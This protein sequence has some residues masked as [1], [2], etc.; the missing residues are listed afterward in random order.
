MP[1]GPRGP[2]RGMRG[3]A[4]RRAVSAALVPAC[5]AASGGLATWPPRSA[6]ARERMQTP[7]ETGVADGGRGPGADL[8]GHGQHRLPRASPTRPPLRL[9]GRGLRR[10]P[11]TTLAGHRPRSSGS[12]AASRDAAGGG[13]LG[14]NPGGRAEGGS[15][16]PAGWSRLR[17][18]PPAPDRGIA[19]L[20]TGLD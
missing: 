17:L 8:G 7:R 18:D 10:P 20:S 15:A 4:G 11:A 3:T 5:R 9:W 2:R 14:S 16:P 19:L 1:A 12:V 13:V 6:H